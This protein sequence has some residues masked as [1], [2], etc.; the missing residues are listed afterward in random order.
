M[1]KL[2]LCMIV[3]DEE[4]V[5]ERIL[6]CAIKF[7]DEIIIVDTGSNDNTKTICKK[8]T[9]NIYDLPWKNDFSYA[10]NFSFSKASMDYIIWLDADDYITES[11]IEKIIELKNSNED[12][13][14]FML[15]Y[16]MA[17]DENN[18]PTFEF[19]RERIIKNNKNFKWE[20]FVHEAISPSG[21]IIY[22]DIE[23]EHRKEKQN[24]PKRNLNL[25][26]NAL[27]KK[28]RFS[29]REQYYYSRELYYNSYYKKAIL[30]LKKYLNM[31]DRYTPNII[32]AYNMLSEC[33]FKINSPKKALDTMFESLKKFTPTPE[34]CCMLARIFE[35]LNQIN[36]TIF[37]YNIAL[38]SPNQTDGFIQKDYQNFIPYLELCR[39]YFNHDFNKSKEYFLKAK[40]IKPQNPSVIFNEQFFK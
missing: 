11:N 38:I 7:C 12:A 39:I 31:S 30:E 20:G 9:E 15:K 14:F 17:F 34:N 37:W 4:D 36:Q 18:K 22:K 33:Y 6:K 24:K 28:C 27:R 32:G 19:F 10:R 13:D 23:I 8:Y 16:C 21:K 26:R 1:F 5:I 35:Q 29:P 2:S 40:E 25:Y 3:R